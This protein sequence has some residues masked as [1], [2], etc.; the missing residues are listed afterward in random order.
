MLLVSQSISDCVIESNISYGHQTDHSLVEINIRDPNYQR[1]RGTWKLN[2]KVLEETAYQE[3]IKQTVS[4]T[5]EESPCLALDDVWTAIKRNCTNFSKKYCR[6][7]CSLE[8]DR[9][10][11]L[12]VAVENLQDDLNTNP[13]N[14]DAL[15]SLQQINHEIRRIDKT[16]TEASIFRSRAKWFREG[17][18]STKFFFSLE[19]RRY[20][21]KN[22]NC[23]IDDNG[24]IIN[25]RDQIL[26]EQTKFYTRLY[27]KNPNAKFTLSREDWEPKLSP[28]EQM[29]CEQ[30]LSTDEIFDAIMTLR[31]GKCPGLNGLTIEFYRKFFKI[32][33]E[34][35][36]KMYEQAF[37]NSILPLSTRRG[38]MSLLPKRGKDSRYLKHRRALVL[39]NYDYKIL[40]KAMDNRLRVVLDNIIDVTQTDFVKGRNITDNIRK[41]LDIIEY[42]KLTK[43]TSSNSKCGHGKMFR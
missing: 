5:L 12:C 30:P 29:S 32:L 17:E 23:V 14:Q 43:Q 39:L 21:E 3:G 18:L 11:K 8:K 22:M 31:S 24:N 27:S 37:A 42:C 13:S 10:N 19:K 25:D 15:N 33:R 6:S 36:L 28:V 2:N 20:L 4:Q 41:T 35:L 40:A 38:V 7:K 34:P 9:L 26:D 16:K 1:G